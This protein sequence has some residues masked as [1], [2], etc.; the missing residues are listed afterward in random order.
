MYIIKSFRSNLMLFVIYCLLIIVMGDLLDINH[1]PVVNQLVSIMNTNITF[2][3]GIESSIDCAGHGPSSE[4]PWSLVDLIDMFDKYAVYLPA[5][6][7]DGNPF[8]WWFKLYKLFLCDPVWDSTPALQWIYAF[9]VAR[10]TFLQSPQS[11]AIIEEW[12]ESPLI[13]M[14]EFVTPP[15]GF[16]CFNDFFIRALQPG[17]R[18][19][20]S[21]DDDSIVVSPAD[22]TIKEI[23][24]DINLNTQL[25]LKR[26]EHLNV[27]ALLGSEDLAK[28]FI[29]GTAIQINIAGS[30]YHWWHAPVGGK[31]VATRLLGGHYF[32]FVPLVH[33]PS[34]YEM[35]HRGVIIF[36]E[37]IVGQVAIIP[38]GLAEVGSILI[39]I[40]E[41][42]NVVKGQRVGRFG[43]GGSAMLILFDSD[44]QLEKIPPLGSEISVR[45]MLG[46]LSTK[47][48][49]L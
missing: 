5:A 48:H 32:G 8:Y 34:Q 3:N 35:L 49:Q 19:I 27:T 14:S 29:G 22:S 13:N 33:T 47:H 21:P 7:P 20:A 43:M 23:Y 44:H 31:V 16:T 36:E 30:N 9:V 40:Q 37:E 15:S 11:A 24:N 46:Q 10:G 26:N 12:L 6:E 41:G 38:V 18:P 17:V 28:N 39:D 45:E 25:H 1:T 42:D 2:R 4:E